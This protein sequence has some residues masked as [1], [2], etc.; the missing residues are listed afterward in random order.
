LPQCLE[1]L[2]DLDQLGGLLPG[3]YAS[4]SHDVLNCYGLAFVNQRKRMFACSRTTSPGRRETYPA[5]SSSSSRQAACD[6]FACT[7]CA[8]PMQRIC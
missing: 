4:L 8:I 3:R 2:S 1:L 7:I 5:P 6:A